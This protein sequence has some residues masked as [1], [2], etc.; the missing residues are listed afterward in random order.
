MAPAT[1]TPSRVSPIRLEDRYELPE[2]EV[3]LSGVQ[4]LVRL[5]LDQ[6]RADA[7]AGQRTGIL[8]SGYQGSP[9]GGFD[10]ELAGLGEVARRHDLVH[11]PA[12]NEELGATAV[13]GSQLVGTLPNPLF[14]G[15]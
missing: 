5:L 10:I 11:R 8:A 12:V 7:E 3:F 1:L 6:H 15:V 2:G 4:A 14:A 9:L 13:W